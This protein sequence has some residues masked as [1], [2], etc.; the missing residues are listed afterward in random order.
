[1]NTHQKPERLIL[2]DGHAVAFDSWFSSGEEDV[3]PGFIHMLAGVVK[4]HDPAG[5]II[6]FD[7]PPPTFRHD[8]YPDYKANR[9]MPPE[10]F[11]EEC[12]ELYELL[13][14]KGITVSRVP[15]F[16]ADD[17][18][19]T[20]NAKASEAG[21]ETIIYTCDLDILQ[22]LD[23][24]TT[25]EVFSQ[26]WPLRTFDVESAIRRFGG[27]RPANIPD[28]KALMGDRSDNL[29]GVPG[30]GEK[31]ATAVLAETTDLET[32]Y[33]DVEIVTRMGIRGAKRI[34]RLLTEHMEDAFLMKKLTTIVRDVSTGVQL[35]DRC[36]SASEIKAIR[37]N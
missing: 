26:Y 34:T 5:L 16:E 22:L 17:L 36:I 12:E 29:P 21:M 35:P 2:V 33:E 7:P 13:E 20:L 11:L 14:S 8:L 32:L 28:L 27:I 25:V 19:G 6:T 9:P 37:T 3:I 15:G 30:I 23:E 18:L 4:R 24:N 31:S 10:E 1:M